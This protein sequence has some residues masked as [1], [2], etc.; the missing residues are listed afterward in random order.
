MVFFAFGW[1]WLWLL[2]VVSDGVRSR[3]VVAVGPRAV[4]AVSPGEVIVVFGGGVSGVHL[5]LRPYPDLGSSSDRL[6]HAAWLFKTGKAS[7]SLLSGGVVAAGDKSE[8]Q[9]MREFL[10]DFRVPER[11]FALDHSSG[12][13]LANGRMMHQRLA[14][15]GGDRIILVNMPRVQRIFKRVEFGVIPSPTDFEVV[16]MPFTLLHIL[17]DVVSLQWRAQTMVEL[18]GLV[19]SC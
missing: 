11:A 17:P 18:F 6:W 12:N 4:E 9:I 14:S 10:V 15:E 8:A 7:R 3:I 2:P 16:E 19:L 5:P 1:L 13:T